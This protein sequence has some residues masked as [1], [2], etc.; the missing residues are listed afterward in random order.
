MK[1]EPVLAAQAL[2]GTIVESLAGGTVENRVANLAATSPSILRIPKGAGR[3]AHATQQILIGG[4]TGTL[5]TVL[6]EAPFA[7]QAGNVAFLAEPFRLVLVVGG[8]AARPTSLIPYE[9]VGAIGAE[10]AVA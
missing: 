1:E 7:L 9:L 6:S 8:G 3:Y 5:G 4:G 10:I 2:D